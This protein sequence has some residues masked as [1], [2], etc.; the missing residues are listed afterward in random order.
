MI[1]SK[2]MN[3]YRNLI[4]WIC[5]IAL[6]SMLSAQKGVEDGSKYGHGQDSIE[7]IRN[8]TISHDF[9][10]QGN[11]SM[12]FPYWQKAFNDCPL[13]TKNLYIDGVR[14]YKDLLD[15]ANE[16]QEIE[17]LLDSLMLI[18]D[19]RIQY[20]NEKANVRGRQGVDL[21]RYGRNETGNIKKAYGYLKEAI[22]IDKALTSEPVLASYFSSSIILY[23][24]GIFK[25]DVVISDYIFISD[26]I[27]KKLAK[28]SSPELEDIKAAI[29]DNFINQGPNNCDTII[30]YFA[31]EIEKKKED[32]SFLKMLTSL[33]EKRNC[34]ESELY[35]TALKTLQKQTPGS[36]VALK[37]AI[38]AYK[39]GDYNAAID[40]YQQAMNLETFADKKADYYFGQAACYNVLKNKSK[41]RELALHAA[42]IRTNWGEPY[43]LIGQMYAD[44]KDECSGIRL[45]NS[46]YWAA[47]DKFLK[48]K[49][50]DPSVTER[51]NSLIITY[52]PYFPNKEKAF[53]ENV[54]EGDSFTVG[55]WINETTQARFNN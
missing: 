41:A 49:M 47:V 53:F 54:H 20:F 22:E 6:P 13:A 4:G 32:V 46:I 1:N 5:L 37:A 10:K 23:Q 16:N 52:S 15:N 50:V 42:E 24:N 29:D 40:L 3:I 14:I 39:K 26:L 45:P 19:R 18:Y 9:V 7:C 44:S 11:F 31:K 27:D 48:A 33:L 43:I 38:L 51:A 25:A 36:D 55:C 21:L 8:M 12:A 28:K 17:S 30:S 34:T 35:Y 2:K